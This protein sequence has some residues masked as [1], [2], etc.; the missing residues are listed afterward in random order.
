MLEM[1]Y[2]SLHIPLIDFE[3]VS[4]VRIPLGLAKDNKT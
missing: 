3:P 1:V 4:L 2:G